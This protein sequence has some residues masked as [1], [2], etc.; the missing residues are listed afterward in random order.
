MNTQWCSV[1]N[2]IMSVFVSDSNI[3][4]TNSFTYTTAI[5]DS[6][7]MAKHEQML[8][9]AAKEYVLQKLGL[10]PDDFAATSNRTWIALAARIVSTKPTRRVL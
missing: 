6:A 9:K 2:A 10:N 7:S 4:I 5:V 8:A 1:Y 3:A